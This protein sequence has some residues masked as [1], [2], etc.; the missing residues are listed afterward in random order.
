VFFCRDTGRLITQFGSQGKGESKLVEPR[1][2][3][4]DSQNNIIV[5]DGGD[6]SVKKFNAQVRFPVYK[7]K[8]VQLSRGIFRGPSYIIKY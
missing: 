8:L 6:C 4:C 7:F 3:A 2:V 5:S 1:Y